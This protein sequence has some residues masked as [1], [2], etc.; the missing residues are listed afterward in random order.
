MKSEI[1]D[2]GSTDVNVNFTWHLVQRDLC[3]YTLPKLETE[4]GILR[5]LIWSNLALNLLS[6]A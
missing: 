6:Y 5:I 2:L 1:L 4:I 3:S